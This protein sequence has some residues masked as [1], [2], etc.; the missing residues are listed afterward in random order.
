MRAAWTRIIYVY[1]YIY[2]YTHIH[3]YTYMC[4]G[5]CIGVCVFVGGRQATEFGPAI[6]TFDACSL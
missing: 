2:I 1:M 4:V 5:G 6:V 3:T